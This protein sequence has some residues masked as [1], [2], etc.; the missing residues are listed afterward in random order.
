MDM[1]ITIQESVYHSPSIQGSIEQIDS[2]GGD[3]KRDNELMKVRGG[4]E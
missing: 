2:L 1:G 4:K 3:Y